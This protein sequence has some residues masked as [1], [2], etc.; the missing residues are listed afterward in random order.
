L[1]KDNALV[2]DYPTWKEIRATP[3]ENFTI[4][5]NVSSA[6]D[7]LK[8]IQS[9][10]FNDDSWAFRGQS[11][12]SWRLQPSIER[13]ASEAGITPQ[14]EKYVERE[15]KRRAHHYISDLPDDEDALEWLALMQHH[16]APTRLLDWTRSA[17]VAAFFAA[18]SAGDAPFAIWAADGW[19]FRR[20]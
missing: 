7:L 14:V 18:E 20:I 12:A 15:F 19:V 13:L 1:P 9:P 8:C 5:Q 16:G 2:P 4:A 17:Y 3:I 6:A 10:P 11:K